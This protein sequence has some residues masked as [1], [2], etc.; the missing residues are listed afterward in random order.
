MTYVTSVTSNV[1]RGCSYDLKRHVLIVGPNGS[2]KS[3]VLHALSLALDGVAY[4]VAGN[5][6]VKAAADVARYLGHGDEALYARVTLSDGSSGGWVREGTSVTHERCGMTFC[7]L[8]A[9]LLTGNNETKRRELQGLMAPLATDADFEAVRQTYPDASLAALD[10]YTA[11]DAKFSL[12]RTIERMLH[13]AIT[14]AEKLKQT[15]KVKKDTETAITSLSGGAGLPVTDEELHAA[16]GKLAGLTA[17]ATPGS[18]S[19]SMHDRAEVEFAEAAT[20][21]AAATATIAELSGHFD[22]WTAYRDAIPTDVSAYPADMLAHMEYIARYSQGLAEQ[23]T[24][25]CFLCGHQ[26]GAAQIATRANELLTWIADE[27][28]KGKSPQLDAANQQLSSILAE[29]NAAKASLQRAADSMRR[30]DEMRKAP[31]ASFDPIEIADLSRTIAAYEQR[32]ETHKRIAQ[33]K[34]TLATTDKQIRTL[35]LVQQTADSLRV[36]L[37]RAASSRLEDAVSVYMPAG[38]RFAVHEQDPHIMIG[39]RNAQGI[40][41]AAA[42]GAEEAALL[43]AIAAFRASYS[44]QGQIIVAPERQWSPDHLAATMKALESAPCQVIIVS[45][46][47]PAGKI[48][49][50]VWSVIDTGVPTSNLSDKAPRTPDTA[51]DAGAVTAT[52]AA[53]P[54]SP[55]PST[56]AAKKA[57]PTPPVPPTPPT[58]PV[59]TPTHLSPAATAFL[60]QNLLTNAKDSPQW[61][62]SWFH[63]TDPPSDDDTIVA[64]WAYGKNDWR[65]FPDTTCATLLA[66]GK[67]AIDHGNDVVYYIP[68]G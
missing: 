37:M 50:S 25:T 13:A 17:G 49:R 22:A 33:L 14:A 3:S 2:G 20:A 46:V 24:D 16:R 4:D 68:R 57:P 36:E 32:I 44:A 60:Q 61:L 26:A 53:Q 9:S 27:R 39:F 43:L 21:H 55:A 45:T 28:G 66:S 40:F 23:H 38:M 65:P 63:V 64:E 52:V 19:V 10:A 7:A 58:P 8:G 5:A 15:K 48:A 42:S 31:V 35:E 34:E 12:M 56:K 6:E 30:A 67:I 29:I 62:R 59:P 51:P 11:E 47:M 1:K 54:T 41:R 18:I